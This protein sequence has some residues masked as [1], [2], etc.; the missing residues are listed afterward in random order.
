MSP[1]DPKPPAKDHVIYGIPPAPRRPRGFVPLRMPHLTRAMLDE[2][3]RFIRGADGDGS[4]R[5]GRG[6]NTDQHS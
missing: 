6:Q 3:D 5:D 1:N 4:A 2:I